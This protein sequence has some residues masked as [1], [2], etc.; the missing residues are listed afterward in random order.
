VAKPEKWLDQYIL[1]WQWFPADFSA[2]STK[3][4]LH[5]EGGNPTVTWQNFWQ[6]P[7]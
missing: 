5:P 1:F 4:S 6:N 7:E 3:E 2:T